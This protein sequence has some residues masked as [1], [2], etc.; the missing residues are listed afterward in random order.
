[1]TRFN[2]HMSSHFSG[3]RLLAEAHDPHR[4]R[5]VSLYLIPGTV[6]VVGVS[7]G[8]DA[9]VAPALA[10][11]FSVNVPDILRRIAVGEHVAPIR[12]QAPTPA[13]RERRAVISEPEPAPRS[14][15]AMLT[16]E[17]KP[18]QRRQLIA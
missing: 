8:V 7:D 9:W 18:R 11:C 17:A 14:R 6:E 2:H 1:M 12:R 5:E 13:K 4:N 10:H 3:C 16:E 15:R